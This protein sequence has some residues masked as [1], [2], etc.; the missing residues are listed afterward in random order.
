MIFCAGFGTRLKP[1]TDFCPKPLLP[2]NKQS[3]LE[4][5][6]KTLNLL[7]FEKIIINTHYLAEQ[8]LPLQKQYANIHLINEHDILET[9]GGIINAIPHLD[10]NIL[11]IN[12]DIWCENLYDILEHMISVYNEN[13]HDNLLGLVHK[14]D[15]LFF[16]GKGD[17]FIEKTTNNYSQIKHKTFKNQQEAPYIFSGIQLWKKKYI[18]Q[19][20]PKEKR[21]SMRYYFD[22]ADKNNSLYGIII[23]QKWCDIGTF[24]V[25]K[26]MENFL[27]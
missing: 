3:C 23:Q 17:Y 12:G 15:A 5:I 20:Q 14:K 27:S 13:G 6:L 10:E 8:F 24:E 18:R 1:L 22:C 26:K 21:F 11:M 16:E 4:R 25:F 9:G 7:K 19:H 2:L